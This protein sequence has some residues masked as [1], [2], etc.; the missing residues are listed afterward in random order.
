MTKDE[1]MAEEIKA[2]ARNKIIADIPQGKPMNFQHGK[3][4]TFKE[5]LAYAKKR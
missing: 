1:E 4:R 3:K 5:L 2:N